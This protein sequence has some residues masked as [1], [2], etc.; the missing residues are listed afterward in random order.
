MQF[1]PKKSLPISI[2]ALLISV[3]IF[4][5][6]AFSQFDDTTLRNS[7]IENIEKDDLEGEDLRIRKAAIEA[8]GDRA[9]T[10]VV[11]SPQSGRIYT[12]VN[13]DWGIRRGFKP[14][15]TIKLVTGVAGY[16]ES[17]IQPS[18]FLANGT[19]RRGLNASLAY[20]DNRFFQ[21]VGSSLGSDRLISYS[22][23]MGLGE[24][25]G[26]NAP[27]EFAGKLPFGNENLRV[28]SHADD[29][30]ITPLQ[31]AVL[32]SAVSNGGDLVIPQIVKSTYSTAKFR[33]YYKRRLDLEPTV[34]ER[35]IP[36]MIGAVEYGT[37]KQIN[38]PH[39]DIAGKTGSC[40]AN[41]TWVGLFASVAPIKD[42]KFAII[43]ITEGKYARG[44]H[45]A[46]V[47][48]NIYSSLRGRYNE[49]YK[50]KLA[51]KAVYTNTENTTASGEKKIIRVVNSADMRTESASKNVIVSEQMPE[52]TSE[53]K[54]VAKAEVKT[55]PK[56]ENLFP[57]VVIGGKTEISRPRI[58]KNH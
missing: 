29:F 47:A 42:P 58:V 24:I 18:G 15:S 54:R 19:Y 22:R 23:K 11:M 6:S 44:K 14:C 25:T 21:K 27:G 16:N 49:G 46:A 41:G 28:Y 30:E 40:I 10:V 33:G 31:L 34:F 20:S 13:Q 45:S 9:G 35:V 52:K 26:I 48:G 8:L 38:D 37:A 5:A 53:S 39:L 36:G 17:L 12:I 50:G 43:V 7:T 55:P 4:T 1:F 3:S 32:V 57:T 2:L 51:R 56:A